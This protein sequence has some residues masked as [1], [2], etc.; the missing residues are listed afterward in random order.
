MTELT[1]VEKRANGRAQVD[2]A[3]G[4]VVAEG[5][6]SIVWH[7]LELTLPPELPATF[8][9]DMVEDEASEES[10]NSFALHAVRDLLGVDQWK[11]ARAKAREERLGQEEF[12]A[13]VN[14]VY[15]R[16]GMA[17]GEAPAS[18]DS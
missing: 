16:F 13:L 3:R 10:G 9:F 14:L 1:A 18:P 12:V 15:S 4:E 11:Q 6:K 7:G 8:F 5:P 17:P 2:A